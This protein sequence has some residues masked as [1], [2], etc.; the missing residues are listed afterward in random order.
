MLNE[1]FDLHRSMAE[2]GIPIPAVHP[3]YAECPSKRPMFKVFVGANARIEDL[4]IV[5]DEERRASIYKYVARNQG[6]SFPAF[7]VIPILQAADADQKKAV[8]QLKQII[9]NKTGFDENRFHSQL[10]RVWETCVHL[11][12][13]Q[14]AA[15][16]EKCLKQQAD[17]LR[18]IVGVIP[19][20]YESIRALF[21]RAKLVNVERL[22]TD[23]KEIIVRHIIDSPSSTTVKDWVETLLVTAATYAL[24]VTLAL[25]LADYHKY[26]YPALYTK[27][28]EW[29]GTRLLQHELDREKQYCSAEMDAF[30][31]PITQKDRE[32]KYLPVRVAAF[33]RD[34]ILRSMFKASKC[35]KRYGRIESESFAAGGLTQRQ[36]GGAFKWLGSMPQKEKTWVKVSGA[37]GYKQAILFAY[38]SYLPQA[39]LELAGLFGNDEVQDNRDRDQDGAGFS[40]AASRVIPA[41]R[42]IVKEHPE[43][44]IRVF[45]LAKPDKGRTKLLVSKRYEAKRLIEAAQ[46]WQDGCRNLPRIAIDIGLDEPI[47]P[48]I[49]YPVEVAR[50]LNMAWLQ[51]GNRVKSVH[52]LTIDEDISLL[53]GTAN[54][55]YRI[56]QKSLQLVTSNAIPLLLT[57]GHADHRGDNSFK[58]TTGNDGTIKYAKH[59]NVLLGILGLL[60]YKIK[61]E[62]GGYMNNAPYL[63]GRMLSLADI[64]HKEY[65]RHEMASKAPASGQDEKDSGMPRQLIGNAAMH[66]ALT[67]LMD[68]LN[69]LAERILIYQAWANTAPEGKTGLAGWALGE[70]GK[71][72]EQ[73]RTMPIPNTCD[74]AAKVQVLLGYLA[75]SDKKQ[76]DNH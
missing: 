67:N 70:L 47:R 43:T 9:T 56:V 48:Y 71:V 23:L 8:A 63:V 33:G 60:L 34:V 39:P 54:E 20:D 45:V 61:F 44:E 21:D 7:S 31:Q 74:D 40:A 65:C 42:G 29:I 69:R 73:L 50:C 1:L 66:I 46:R 10:E 53:L 38:P 15:R 32:E 16:I 52:G 62:K 3:L 68:A 55:T 49:P 72:S 58:W 64:L 30:G 76:E 5:K 37:S 6:Y 57:L 19:H 41:V 18:E 27:T 28:Q 4:E 2:A 24:N 25:E 35:Q 26:K 12:P 17:E 11:W 75:R 13:N 36:A 22:T 14:M 51:E 59:A